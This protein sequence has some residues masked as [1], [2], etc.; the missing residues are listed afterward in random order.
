[1]RFLTAA[2]ILAVI[3]GGV[4]WFVTAPKPLD[5]SATASLTGDA[6][7]GEQVF[8]A[9]GCASCHMAEG[10]KGDA[11]LMLS[12]GQAFPS[13]FGTFR[14]PNITPDPTF[15]IGGWS[16]EAFA[17]AVTRGVSPKGQHYYP[18]FPYNAYN[19]MKLQDIADL[20]AFMDTLP[21]SA[22]PSQP[23]AVGFPFNIR[24]LL[25]GWKFLFVSDGWVIKGDLT[26]E[27]T[28]G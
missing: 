9:T 12:G 1:M 23:H 5:P 3:G 7:H 18:A 21:P 24:R 6:T 28:R 20:K 26:P 11:Q 27:E 4:F 10:A 17:N 22:V 25:G 2:A 14:A 16:L 8:W 15:G 19:K 13:D